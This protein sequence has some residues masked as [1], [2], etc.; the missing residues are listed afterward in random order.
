MWT[1][2]MPEWAEGLERQYV[3][4]PVDVALSPIRPCVLATGLVRRTCE[5][6]KE[7]RRR[8]DMSE[9]DDWGIKSTS[10]PKHTR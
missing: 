5:S 2:R 1:G 6:I 4:V 3:F 9:R 7:M 10:Y 8:A